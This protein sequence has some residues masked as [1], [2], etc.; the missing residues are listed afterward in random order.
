[1]GFTLAEQLNA[2][3]GKGVLVGITDMVAFLRTDAQGFFGTV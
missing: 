3:H 1:M 2:V